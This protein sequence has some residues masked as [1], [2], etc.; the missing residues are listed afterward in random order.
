MP[1]NTVFLLGA[2][3]LGLIV[4]GLLP[5]PSYPVTWDDAATERLLR[6]V[7]KKPAVTPMQEAAAERLLAECGYTG[8]VER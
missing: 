7:L 4:L 5:R 8:E 1:S 3:A 2:I 6:D